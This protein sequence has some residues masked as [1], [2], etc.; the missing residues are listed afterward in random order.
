MSPIFPSGMLTAVVGP[1][2]SGKT[3]LMTS[4]LG[5]LKADEGAVEIFG[6]PMRGRPRE[7]LRR[8]GYV[9]DVDDGLIGEL[10]AREFWD[11]HALA[12]A[13]VQG[14]VKE[15]RARAMELAAVLDFSPPPTR[16]ASFSHGMVKKTQIVAGLLHCPDLAIFDEPRSSLDPIAMERF[17][18]LI[19]ELLGDG[20]AVILATHDLRYA[21]RIAERALIIAAGQVGFEGSMKEAVRGHGDLVRAFFSLVGRGREEYSPRYP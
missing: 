11:L 6:T 20:V 13:R 19:G 18:Q 3:T 17:D 1:N 12:H 2:G 4:I 21:E 7:I 9:P 14:S 15:M 16:I 10:T 5:L 8:V